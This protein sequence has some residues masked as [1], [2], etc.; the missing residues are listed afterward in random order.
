MTYQSIED[1]YFE[2][3]EPLRSTLLFIRGHL[4]TDTDIS[5]S[6]KYGLPFFD[7]KQKYFCYFHQDKKSKTPYLA[8]TQGKYI[9]HSALSM[10]DRKQI[11]VLHF[12]PEEDFPVDILDEI[13][14]LAKAAHFRS[15]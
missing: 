14:E 3:K 4:L 15:N 1:Y 7:Y 12:R 9:D 6:W 13:L 2:Q 11:A 5:E 10:G 8:F